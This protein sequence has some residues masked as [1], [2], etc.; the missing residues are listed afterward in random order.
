MALIDCIQLF[1]EDSKLKLTKRL[2]K[3]A[4]AMSKMTVVAELEPEGQLQYRKLTIPEFL[5][6]IARVAELN[7]KD[8]ELEDL[9]LFQKVE[10]IL[11]DILPV[12]GAERVKQTI[13]VEEFS[14]SD[15]DY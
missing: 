8:S 4:F 15:D 12:I 2:V 14:D 9:P 13:T 1:K 11:D 7:F 6:V 3:E 10:H 5:E